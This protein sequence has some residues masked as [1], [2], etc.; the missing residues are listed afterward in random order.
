VRSPS[1]APLEPAALAQEDK[2]KA[3]DTNGDGTLSVEEVAA[4][5]PETTLD[6]IAAVDLNSSGSLTYD[7]FEIDIEEGFLVAA[8]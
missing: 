5:M 3:F 2:F 7:E 4:G 1:R 8:N 6:N